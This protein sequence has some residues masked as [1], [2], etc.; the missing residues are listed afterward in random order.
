MSVRAYTRF[1]LVGLNTRPVTNLPPLIG[2]FAHLY[3][4]GAFGPRQVGICRW[5]CA[6]AVAAEPGLWG[7][8]VVS[9][10]TNGRAPTSAAAE[11]IGRI[12][13]ARA[14]TRRGKRRPGSVGS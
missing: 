4:A 11:P 2:A 7:S 5:S 12:Y 9:R 8:P 13:A 6:R 3:L 14:A 10:T 1:F